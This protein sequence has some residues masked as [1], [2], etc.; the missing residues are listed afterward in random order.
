MSG[1][2]A[3]GGGDVL[4]LLDVRGG[5]AAER[6][7]ERRPR[8]VA[9][10]EV[11]DRGEDDVRDRRA[12]PVELGALQHAVAARVSRVAVAAEARRVVAHLVAE[13][14]GAEA[15]VAERLLGIGDER[16]RD[17]GLDLER[18][19]VGLGARRGVRRVARQRPPAAR[20]HRRHRLVAGRPLQ[21]EHAGDRRRRPLRRRPRDRPGRLFELRLA[22][23]GQHGAATLP[24][25]R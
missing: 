22:V 6:L 9:R 21:R 18:V 10:P 23:A 12:V 24:R 11:G 19:V 1:A 4:A 3:I 7:H 13:V 8:P 2:G 17:P 20:E 16:H 25:S 5:R 14:A 15:E